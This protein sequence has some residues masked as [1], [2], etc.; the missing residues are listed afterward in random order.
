M[1]YRSPN[2][3][4][5]I[6]SR[7]HGVVALRKRRRCLPGKHLLRRIPDTLTCR[8]LPL[9]PPARLQQPPTAMGDSDL[10]PQ[11]IAA[12]HCQPVLPSHRQRGTSSFRVLLRLISYVGRGSQHWIVGIRRLLQ[13]VI[14]QGD[15]VK[16]AAYYADLRQPTD[17][18]RSGFMFV[19]ILVGDI[20]IVCPARFCPLP[21]SGSPVFSPPQ[22][23][24]VWLVWGRD[25]RVIILPTLTVI[26]LAGRD[27]ASLTRLLP[28]DSIA[29]VLSDCNRFDVQ[30][31]RRYPQ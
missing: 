10:G 13:A 28:T 2:P 7:H 12:G 18:I 19:G 24:R 22:S 8:P 27:A 14:D 1:R 30:N 11:K 21:T 29:N 6:S 16:A 3:H 9:D 20:N 15:A 26:G 23:Y 25:F 17:I 5:R 31:A 4:R